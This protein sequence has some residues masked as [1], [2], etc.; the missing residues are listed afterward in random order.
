MP[1]VFTVLD[2]RFWQVPV[3]KWS[4][5]LCSFNKEDDTSSPWVLEFQWL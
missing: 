5:H 3:L 1:N 4:T 2:T